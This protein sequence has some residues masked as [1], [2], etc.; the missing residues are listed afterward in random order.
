[1]A[2]GYDSYLNRVG[3]AAGLICVI[4]PGFSAILE[5]S[6][7]FGIGGTS[8]TDELNDN[9][10]LALGLRLDTYGHNFILLISNAYQIGERRFMDGTAAGPQGSGVGG[11]GFLDALYLGF[12]I[13]RRFDFSNP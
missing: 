4:V 3:F 10:T 9:P 5:V 2:L 8:H 11:S 6:P 7:P 13:R 1:V 12:T